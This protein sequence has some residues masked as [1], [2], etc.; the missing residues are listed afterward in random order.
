VP[1]AEPH[2]PPPENRPSKSLL[3]IP[4]KPS[5]KILASK[6]FKTLLQNPCPK[7]LAPK[8]VLQNPAPAANC[9]VAG[10]ACALAACAL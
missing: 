9:G 8:S 2:S 6:S 10:V 1:P 3:Q 5:F 7:I 4:S